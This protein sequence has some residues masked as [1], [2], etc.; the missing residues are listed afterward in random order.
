MCHFLKSS[1]QFPFR[2]ILLMCFPAYACQRKFKGEEI[3]TLNC[4]IYNINEVIMT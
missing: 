2:A 3:Q 1:L 4:Y